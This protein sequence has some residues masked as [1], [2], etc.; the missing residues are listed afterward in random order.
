MDVRIGRLR[1]QVSGMSQETARQVGRLVAEQ[2]ATMV[3]G[4]SP[5]SGVAALTN[6]HVSV[7][8]PVGHHPGTVAQAIAAEVSRALRP[9]T[10]GP[11]LTGPLL[12]G[13]PAS[14]STVATARPG[15]P[16]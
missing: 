2:L 10:T 13:R 11:V 3:A 8:A 9:G 6:L 15:A 1:L 5:G 12:T 14:D 4:T 16:R 7:T